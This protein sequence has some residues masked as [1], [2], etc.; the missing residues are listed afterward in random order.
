[1]SDDEV[2]RFGLWRG[3]VLG[4]LIEK[5]PPNTVRLQKHEPCTD[6]IM[7]I[8]SANQ[9]VARLCGERGITRVGDLSGKLVDFRQW[10]LDSNWADSAILAKICADAEAV[11]HL[12]EFERVLISVDDAIS[13][14][15]ELYWPLR[16]KLHFSRRYGAARTRRAFHTAKPDSAETK[17][18]AKR[19]PR[20]QEHAEP[21][22]VD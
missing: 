14:C 21:T 2:V 18:S 5:M 1:M 3:T 4:K 19:E 15:E 6:A 8:L 7:K 10:L 16:K 12:Q 9:N 11:A 20:Q 13:L 22:F 17:R